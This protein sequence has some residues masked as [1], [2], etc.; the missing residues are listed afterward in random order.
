[1]TER[2]EWGGICISKALY[3]FVNNEAL[4]GAEVDRDHFWSSLDSMIRDLGPRN[5]ALLQRG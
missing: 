4:E 5:R 3:E 1:M 2:I